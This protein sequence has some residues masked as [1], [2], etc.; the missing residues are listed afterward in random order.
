MALQDREPVGFVRLAELVS[1]EVPG[2]NNYGRV[3]DI[4]ALAIRNGHVTERLSAITRLYASMCFELAT[5]YAEREF[6][7]EIPTLP[8]NSLAP[9]NELI[10]DSLSK[11]V[12][13]MLCA[14]CDQSFNQ[15]HETAVFLTQLLS[16]KSSKDND[17]KSR[18]NEYTHFNNLDEFRTIA[19]LS[20]FTAQTSGWL[21][22]SEPEPGRQADLESLLANLGT[23]N[24]SLSYRAIP[25]WLYFLAKLYSQVALNNVGRLSVHTIF[26]RHSTSHALSLELIRQGFPLLWPTQLESIEKA[27]TGNDIL[28]VSETGTGK[29]LLGAAM[30]GSK[31]EAEGVSVYA[32]PT[33]ALAYQVGKDMIRLAYGGNPTAV[34]VLTM[35]EEVREEEIKSHKTLV[36]TYEKIEGLFREK[37]VPRDQLSL[38]IIDECHNIADFSRGVTL[39]FLLTQLNPRFSCQ[40]MLLSAVVPDDQAERLARWAKANY[41]RG[42]DWRRTKTVERIAIGRT[43]LE[44]P[45]D[46]NEDAIDQIQARLQGSQTGGSVESYL[47]PRTLSLVRKGKMVLLIAESRSRVEKLASEIADAM[48]IWTHPPLGEAFRDLQLVDKLEKDKSNLYK[49]IEELKGSELV[50]PKSTQNILKLLSR[51]IIFHHAG[52][53]KVVRIILEQMIKDRVPLVV[54]STTTLEAGVNFP[55]DTVLV[56]RLAQTK[57][58][59]SLRNKLESTNDQALHYVLSRYESRLFSAYHNVIGRAG[60]P[61]FSETGESIICFD[62]S[63]EASAFL[64]MRY[65]KHR[66][67]G[68][69][70]DLYAIVKLWRTA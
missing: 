21:M 35:E 28:L 43:E 65:R 41:L 6:L 16:R 3:G 13:D 64:D 67:L 2:E 26:H 39:D 15:A 68:A 19:D 46:F 9:L 45:S 32:V 24:R 63:G 44:I 40:R 11:R 5:E 7:R 17:F 38:L 22:G 54:V 10:T 30:V 69:G 49:Y 53:P 33:R 70:A 23:F 56:K 50:L 60:R 8:A 31:R 12:L 62:S 66:L 52:L 58:F 51:K 55:V 14:Y 42:K 61:G 36:G 4:L 27:I 29:S 18:F 34:K 20:L 59:K 37:L 48:D 57:T 47:I 25:P 1:T